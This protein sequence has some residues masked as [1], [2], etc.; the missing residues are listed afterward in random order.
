METRIMVNAKYYD[1]VGLCI[2]QVN[3][4]VNST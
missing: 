1:E 3:S 4:E 2:T